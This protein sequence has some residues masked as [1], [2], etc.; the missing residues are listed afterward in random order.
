[1]GG[2]RQGTKAPHA[3]ASAISGAPTLGCAR[4][5]GQRGAVCS[6]KPTRYP[7][8]AP[9]T[10]HVNATGVSNGEGPGKACGPT[11]PRHTSAMCAATPFWCLSIGSA[12][13]W[14]NFRHARRAPGKKELLS[15]IVCE[16]EREHTHQPPGPGGNAK[17]ASAL[18]EAKRAKSSRTLWTCIEAL[19]LERAPER[20][21]M[22]QGVLT[23]PGPPFHGLP[24]M[25]RF[26]K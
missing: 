14:H 10:S 1:M 9:A 23:K 11:P 24:V 20:F 6:T 15:H 8:G 19:D 16:R 18:P 5:Q 22:A 26:T 2:D 17:P 4:A 3:A 25:I 21:L 13:S 7:N 12:P